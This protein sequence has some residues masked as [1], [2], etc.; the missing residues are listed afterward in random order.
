MATMEATGRARAAERGDVVL[1]VAITMIAV[2]LVWK[3]D[4]V[5]RT[6][7]RQDDFVFIARGLEQGLSW[8]YLMRVDYGHLVPGPF[9]IQWAMGRL[10]VYN[11]VLAHIVTMGLQAAA[12]LALLR[13]L[14][15]LFG[16]RP[17]ILVPLGFALLTPM[18]ISALSWWAVVIETLPFQI[19]L[20]MALASHVHHVRT[21][22]FRHAVAAAAWTVA[23]MA[24]FVK[25]PF[26]LVL[27][28]V[29]TL[30][31]FPK[32]D[33][34]PAWLLYLVVVAAYAVVFFRQLLTSV[35]ITNDTVRPELPDPA[36]AAGFAWNLLTGA[37]VPTAL[38]GPWRWRPITEDYA[39]ADVPTAAAWAALAVAAAV[40]AFS[41]RHRRRAWLAW[42]TLL[43]Y[44]LLADVVP[45]MIGRIA[46]LGPDLGGSELR[47][48]SSTSVV[49][50][51]VL[52]LAFIPLRGEEHPWL[53][54]L[55]RLRHAW[56]PLAALAAAGSVWSVAAYGRLPLGR[57]VES[58][59][60]TARQ[61][62]RQAPRDAV[63]VDTDVP[64]RVAYSVFFYDYAR[65]S[66]ILGPLAPDTVIWTR[67]LSGPIPNPLT[68]DTDG[69]LR[70][71]VI[72]GATIPQPGG[73]TRV[74]GQERRFRLP[75]PMP[76][77]EWTVQLGYLNP[78]PVR[79]SVRLGGQAAAV[80]AGKDFGWTFATLTGEGAELAVR[81]LDGRT[82]CLGEIRVGVPRPAR[83]GTPI[84][85]Q[86]VRP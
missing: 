32:A 7:F 23:G 54:P 78:E 70:P 56:I 86:P 42:L 43:G 36:T 41:V 49:V 15:L 12:G 50:A 19:A 17:A 18:T 14:R 21:G 34:R 84:P 28:F 72:E 4:L 73:C 62:F 66:R 39:L 45:V 29:L 65:A 63:V 25:S 61:A 31:W 30:G 67:R 79:L 38:G 59:V 64:P 48:I 27:A 81:T 20:P 13:L 35:Q 75:M 9:A 11:D 58:Y 53:R 10:G 69:R 46:Q 52:G 85:A 1:A 68:L 44:F 26:I 6:Y 57:H 60:E 71:V 51:L 47:Y 82:A 2:Q 22:R 16:T 80:P 76:D 3:F 5:R 33:R 55:P 40:V 83:T 77:G 24:F 74:S 8:D 37:L